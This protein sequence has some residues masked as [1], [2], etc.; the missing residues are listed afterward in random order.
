MLNYYLKKMV[1]KESKELIVKNPEKYGFKPLEI[2]TKLSKIYSCFYN[3]DKFIDVIANDEDSYS[4][5]LMNKMINILLKKDKLK[6]EISGKLYNL[7][8]L[9]DKKI[10][11][12]PKEIEYE[13]V[14]A[15]FCD[16][17]LMSII[18]KPALLPNMDLIVEESTIKRHL[19]TCDENPF[20]RTK[21]TLKNLK[22]IIIKKK[23]KLY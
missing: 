13:N 2:L 8:N 9:I 21:L 10:K 7:F 5:S 19:L 4:Q 11:N 15:E 20:N 23:L 14:P 22:N 12:K 16:P 1:G 17:I 6:W 3:N 18:E